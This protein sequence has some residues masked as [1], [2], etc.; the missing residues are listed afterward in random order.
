MSRRQQLSEDEMAKT[1][2]SELTGYIYNRF[3]ATGADVQF[4]AVEGDN[5]WSVLWPNGVQDPAI[6]AAV[7]AFVHGW[8]ANNNHAK[9]GV[10]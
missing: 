8:F 2:Q 3:S 1:L 4:P 7:D 9:D 5:T 10:S 6:S